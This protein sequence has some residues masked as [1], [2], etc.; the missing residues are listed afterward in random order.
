MDLRR[1]CVWGSSTLIPGLLGRMALKKAHT[2]KQGQS[3]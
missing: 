3:A 2:R 1:A